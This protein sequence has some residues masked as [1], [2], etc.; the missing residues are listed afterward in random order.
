MNGAEARSLGVLA[1]DLAGELT[2]RIEELH[3]TVALRAFGGVRRGVGPAVTPVQAV[4]DGIAAALYGGVR[5]A[6]RAGARGVGAAAALVT[7][8]DA[9]SLSVSAS[10]FQPMRMTASPARGRRSTN[11]I[12]PSC[13]SADSTPAVAAFRMNLARLTRFDFPELFGPTSTVMGWSGMVC[14]SPKL[15]KFCRVIDGS[16]R[17]A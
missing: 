1:G 5:A 12:P 14:S 3:R 7:R 10:T 17:R 15:W 11:S 9:P 6:G 16:I 4:H 2:S 13:S 8:P